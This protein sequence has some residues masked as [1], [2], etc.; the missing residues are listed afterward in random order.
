M[1]TE[2]QDALVGRVIRE[3]R[4]AEDALRQL[5]VKAEQQA[6]DISRLAKEV[7]DRVARAKA[8]T[9]PEPP[10]NMPKPPV[11][12]ADAG[13]EFGRLKNYES[14]VDLDAINT[15]DVEI[16]QAVAN[17]LTFREQR[18]KLGVPNV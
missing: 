18:R 1:T 15:L 2:E 5:L 7:S 8:A 9:A 14:A 10:H 16:G 3:S 11:K 4:E 12:L 17:V 6:A 13:I